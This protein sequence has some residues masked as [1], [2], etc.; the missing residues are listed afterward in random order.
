[1]GGVPGAAPGGDCGGRALR[2]PADRGRRS[3]RSRAAGRSRHDDR[4][5]QCAECGRR[6]R[7]R[8]RIAVG[9][10]RRG[11]L[12]GVSP[13]YGREPLLLAEPI[14]TVAAEKVAPQGSVEVLERLAR[15]AVA[16]S[17]KLR[18]ARLPADADALARAV[19]VLGDGADG[20]HA[21]AMAGI[22]RRRLA[23][24]A[25]L[26][27]RVELLRPD[28]PLRFVHPLVRNAVYEASP[29]HERAQQHATAA[30]VFRRP[31]SS[32]TSRR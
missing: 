25:A 7:A 9:R 29:R 23:P 13:G 27:S 32:G 30:A 18:L 14:R 16:R 19:A 6:D 4:P 28:P 1:M 22:E 17:V 2:G 8:P 12:R 10:R 26:L 15:D 31:H 11:V 3:G 24:A 5:A 20:R 21:A